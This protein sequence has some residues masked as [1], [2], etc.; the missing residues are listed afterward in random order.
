MSP[1]SLYTIAI[2]FDVHY[3]VLGGFLVVN[4]LYNDFL[5]IRRLTQLLFL[6]LK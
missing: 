2:K 5:F 1:I 4:D 6:G 3:W